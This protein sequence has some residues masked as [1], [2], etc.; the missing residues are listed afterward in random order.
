M[1]KL[2]LLLVV[3]LTFA[4]AQP[5]ELVR[6]QTDK[7]TTPPPAPGRFTQTVYVHGD[8]RLVEMYDCIPPRNYRREQSHVCIEYKGESVYL[9]QGLGYHL[10]FADAED[11]IVHGGNSDAPAR[12]GKPV[13]QNAQGHPTDLEIEHLSGND[14]VTLVL[15]D[16][17][18][19][20][21]QRRIRF[22]ELAAD[23]KPDEQGLIVRELLAC[24]TYLHLPSAER[25][26]GDVHFKLPDGRWFGWDTYWNAATPVVTLSL[27]GEPHTTNG[28]L[29]NEMMAELERS[30]AEMDPTNNW[31]YHNVRDT[32]LE[33]LYHGHVEQARSMLKRHVGLLHL[34]DATE[35]DTVTRT[36][37]YWDSM[38]E[39]IT[40]S[41]ALRDLLRGEFPQ[42]EE[43]ALLA[44]K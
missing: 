44:A 19:R 5:M 37:R 21:V 34:P 43:E 39:Q 17:G 30:V 38:V 11:F 41:S 40:S 36:E 42:L 32:I 2:S 22:L 7:P 16:A 23:G 14:N 1:Y 28:T 10:W 4:S 25:V 31:T 24:E 18:E 9:M 35:T 8:W 12:T 27:R 3:A 13:W 20:Y 26:D 33:Y 6:S 29:T 15:L